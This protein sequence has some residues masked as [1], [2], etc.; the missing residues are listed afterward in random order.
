[1]AWDRLDDHEKAIESF[2]EAAGVESDDRAGERRGRRGRG[3]RTADVQN[4]YRARALQRLGRNEEARSVFER[5]VA[6]GTESL[7]GTQAVDVFMK[8]GAQ[9]SDRQ[10]VAGAHYVRGLG[11]LGLGDEARARE[12]LTQALQASPD[13]LGAKTALARLQ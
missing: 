8:F 7:Q 11:Y 2:G 13:H 9:Q 1:M 4:Y 10:R 6:S 3:G 12:E 5:L